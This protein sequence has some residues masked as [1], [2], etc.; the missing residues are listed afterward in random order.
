MVCCIA[1]LLC[2]QC[3]M[4]ELNLGVHQIESYPYYKQ[5]AICQALLGL[6]PLA[7]LNYMA[8]PDLVESRALEPELNVK[9]NYSWSWSQLLGK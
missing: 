8:Y 9:F 7:H 2:C 4:A 1:W 5:L 6:T 3:H